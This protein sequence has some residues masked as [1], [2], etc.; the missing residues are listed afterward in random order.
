MKM[1]FV[2]VFITGAGHEITLDFSAYK[3]KLMKEELILT[4]VNDP[5]RSITLVLHARV[6]GM[7]RM[8][9]WV[10]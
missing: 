10:L 3:E 8:A 7:Y 1:Y 4:D 6:L 5:Q 9:I 2:C